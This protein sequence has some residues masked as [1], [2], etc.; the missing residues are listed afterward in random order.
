MGFSLGV[1]LQKVCG[2]KGSWHNA[3]CLVSNARVKL[4]LKKKYFKLHPQVKNV[5][6]KRDYAT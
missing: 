2:I 6:K 4:T 5:T 1:V 3:G